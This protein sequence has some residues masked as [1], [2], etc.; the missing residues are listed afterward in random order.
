[1]PLVLLVIFSIVW[2]PRHV[3]L[4]A[5]ASRWIKLIGGLMGL[6]LFGAIPLLWIGCDDGLFRSVSLKSLQF[7]NLICVGCGDSILLYAPFLFAW[8]GMLLGEYLADRFLNKKTMD[9]LEWKEDRNS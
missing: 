2:F 5:R 3:F 9:N 6:I 8:P 1:M 7:A 4:L